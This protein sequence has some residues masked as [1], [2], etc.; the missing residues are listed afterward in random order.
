MEGEMP[1]YFIVINSFA[2]PI[3]SDT[4]YKHVEAD[5]PDEA[6]QAALGQYSHPC[7]AYAA[8]CFE[9]ADAMHKRKPALARWL[10][11]EAKKNQ[12]PNQ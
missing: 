1:E 3:C 10:S 9:S 12:Q 5:T 7:G 2:A 6:I 8:V 4:S 11:D